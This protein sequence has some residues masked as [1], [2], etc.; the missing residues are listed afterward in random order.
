MPVAALASF[1]AAG[2]ESASL[3]PFLCPMQNPSNVNDLAAHLIDDHV[4]G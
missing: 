3:R 4:G 2:L 1:P